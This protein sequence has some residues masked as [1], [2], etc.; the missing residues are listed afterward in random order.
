[1]A[2]RSVKRLTECCGRRYPDPVT[3]IPDLRRPPADRPLLGAMA[4]EQLWHVDLLARLGFDAVW[5]DAEHGLWSPRELAD[6]CILARRAGISAI[7]RAPRA[8]TNLAQKAL[9]AGAAAL[10][11]PMC[12]SVDDVAAALAAVRFP[13]HGTRGYFGLGTDADYGV[14]EGDYLDAAAASTTVIVQIETRAALDAAADIAQLDGVDLL[15]LGPADLA[16]STGAAPGDPEVVEPAIS[17][18]ASAAAAAGVPWGT[19][20]NSG[21]VARRMTAAGAKLL[22]MSSPRRVLTAAYADRIE[23]LRSAS[24]TP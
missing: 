13:P 24:V 22:A 3:N 14:L 6:A 2:A 21:A 7:V 4:L 8:D 10:M 9:E 12:E 19:V 11:I 16:V 15:F 5:L 20:A 23:E 1:M 18:V 17:V